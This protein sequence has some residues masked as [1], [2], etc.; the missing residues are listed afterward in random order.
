MTKVKEDIWNRGFFEIV[1]PKTLCTFGIANIV[2]DG[3]KFVGKNTPE[4]GLQF[5]DFDGDYNSEEFQKIQEIFPNDLFIY[6]SKHGYH[7]VSLTL[8]DIDLAIRNANTLSR[9]FKNQD[10]ILPIKD[11]R[12]LVLRVA[13]KWNK[14]SKLKISDNPAFLQVVQFPKKKTIISGNHLDFYWRY[15]N[16]PQPIY[17]FYKDMCRIRRGVIYF[18][19]YTTGD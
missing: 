15:M 11:C 7:F 3:E 4:F 9:N 16:L 5:Y 13:P 17:E 14:E 12:Y 2:K 6:K 19:Y 10:Y 18:I 8:M 1:N